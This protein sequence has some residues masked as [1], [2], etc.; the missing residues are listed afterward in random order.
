MGDNT[1]TQLLQEL[2][3]LTRVATY[4]VA[5]DVLRDVF[6]EGG[7]PQMVRVQVYANLDGRPQRE[8]AEVADTSQTSVSKW[9]REWSRIGLVRG[10]GTAV[11]N[12]YD[13]FPE[14]RE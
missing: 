14:L 2:V 12:I 9:S 1:E 13:F 3:E 4:P 10:D 7:E 11:F 5:R 8:I 6:F